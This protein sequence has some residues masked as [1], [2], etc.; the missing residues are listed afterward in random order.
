MPETLVVNGVDISTIA[1]LDGP[2]GIMTAPAKRGGNLVVAG[3]HGELHVPR[4]H[5]GPAE[6]VFPMWLLGYNP[7]L[8]FPTSDT[9]RQALYDAA[10]KVLLAFGAD[11]V[12]VDHGRP[13]GAVRRAV[14]EVLDTM[15]FTRSGHRDSAA[16]V[17]IALD[18]F[19]AF[20][21]DI[22]PVTAGPYS[23]ASGATATLTPFQG[24]TAPMDELLVTI[25][26][27][28]NPSLSQP[29]SAAFV[30]YDG[31]IA[32]GRKLVIDTE[33]WSVTGT[34]D[35]GGTWVPAITALRFGPDSRFFT[36]T[37]PPD[38]S[39]PVIQM[40]NTAGASV[41]VTVSG[42]RRYLTG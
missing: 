17:A 2:P 4:K 20:W 22:N 6:G 19:G 40:T 8:P 29:L 31:V 13:N 14:G 39:P 26:P 15:D 35:A 24:A 37:P 9:A 33:L 18:V 27:G 11:T 16:K 38:G 5:Y 1:H 23:L 3:R 7:D 36:L 30:A 25:G 42:K 32:A 12:T 34:I 41:Q 28:S 21:S 10:D